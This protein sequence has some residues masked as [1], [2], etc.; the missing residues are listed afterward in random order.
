MNGPGSVAVRG[1]AGY[2]ISVQLGTGLFPS[3]LCRQS[4]ADNKS[5]LGTAL[6]FD[7]QFS[8]SKFSLEVAREV[9]TSRRYVD[10]GHRR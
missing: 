7:G 1:T 4:I 8:Q 6:K 9:A 10:A 2:S 5:W 3:R